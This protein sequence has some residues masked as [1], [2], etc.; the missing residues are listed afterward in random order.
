M[1]DFG[2]CQKMQIYCERISKD[3]ICYKPWVYGAF[4]S[5][6]KISLISDDNWQIFCDFKPVFSQNTASI[7]QFTPNKLIFLD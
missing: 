5:I 2:W 7:K 6:R 4:Y 3:S 1:D